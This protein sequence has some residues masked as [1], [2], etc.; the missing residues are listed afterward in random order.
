MWERESVSESSGRQTRCC[1]LLR[2][3]LVSTCVSQ[4]KNLLKLNWCEAS[5]EQTESDKR[6]KFRC[7]VWLF[8]TQ[9]KRSIWRRKKRNPWWWWSNESVFILVEQCC[10]CYRSD[11]VQAN[12]CVKCFCSKSTGVFTKTNNKKNDVCRFTRKVS[13]SALKDCYWGICIQNTWALMSLASHLTDR[14]CACFNHFCHYNCVSIKSVDSVA[15]GA[16]TWISCAGVL[17]LERHFLNSVILSLSG[18]SEN[19][20]MITLLF[21]SFFSPDCLIYETPNLIK[22]YNCLVWEL[23]FYY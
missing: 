20:L 6:S 1:L 9:L 3:Q 14:T 11:T 18:L 7:L 19:L 17:D 2:V 15:K 12:G 23:T 13:M 4:R 10:L 21:I 16:E 8:F 22:F 5:L